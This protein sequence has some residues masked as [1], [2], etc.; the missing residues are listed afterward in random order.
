MTK[1]SK[2]RRSVMK[3][4]S[5]EAATEGE[6]DESLDVARHTKKQRIASE[7]ATSEETSES[8]SSRASFRASNKQRIASEVGDESSSS[9][10]S[11]RASN[12]QRIA[13]EEP[14]ESPSSRALFR[15]SNIETMAAM[16]KAFPTVASTKDA[17]MIRDATT[18]GREDLLTTL[19]NPPVRLNSSA[20]F[21][22]SPAPKFSGA[23]A[24]QPRI[25]LKL[26]LPNARQGFL[27]FPFAQLPSGVFLK[28]LR[29]IKRNEL[30]NDQIQLS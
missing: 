30:K 28:L 21:M 27:P 3:A 15:A 9:Q 17:R 13:S 19:S 25:T 12:K 16:Q 6:M 14:S 20:S 1:L 23:K 22:G 4:M 26:R 8:S 18:S 11:F 7:E 5:N 2:R 10:A 24:V 29:Y